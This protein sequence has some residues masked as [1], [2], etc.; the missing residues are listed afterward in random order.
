MYNTVL[1]N[2]NM[3]FT[4][5]FTIEMMLKLLAFGVRVRGSLMLFLIRW[6]YDIFAAFSWQP[7]IQMFC[8]R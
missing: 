2:L 3:A 6:C 1:T 5:L 8:L 4:T 7:F